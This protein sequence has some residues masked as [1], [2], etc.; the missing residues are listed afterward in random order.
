MNENRKA[1]ATGACADISALIESSSLGAPEAR[2]ARDSVDPE[3]AELVMRLAEH[4][5]RTRMVGRWTE[6]A[7]DH[8]AGVG[9]ADRSGASKHA[10]PA[11]VSTVTV[12]ESARETVVVTTTVT[13][14]PRRRVGGVFGVPAVR[15]VVAT[16]GAGTVATGGA[17]TGES[18]RR[19][20][21]VVV[22]GAAVELLVRRRYIGYIGRP[23]RNSSE[24][25]S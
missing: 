11:S 21:Y 5:R 15:R 16:G 9:R 18:V 24:G 12:Y 13:R 25:G 22:R 4:R 19:R 10:E 2:A 23:N 20:W 6:P 7:A 1:T 8:L 14:R 3:A 17:G